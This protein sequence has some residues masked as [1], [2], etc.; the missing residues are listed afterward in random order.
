MPIAISNVEDCV[1]VCYNYLGPL[2]TPHGEM[3]MARI[4]RALNP[5]RFLRVER[6]Q[7]ATEYAIIVFYSILFVGGAY[8]GIKLLEVALIGYYRDTALLLCLP[9]P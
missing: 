6:G 2:R 7:A 5:A 8:W 9:F 1:F 4:L 3:T